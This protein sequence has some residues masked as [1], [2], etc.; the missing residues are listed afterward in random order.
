MENGRVLVA[1][2]AKMMSA[3]VPFDWFTP[4]ER[5]VRDPHFPIVQGLPN[6]PFDDHN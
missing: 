6:Q 3:R 2:V 5:L 1:G 4:I